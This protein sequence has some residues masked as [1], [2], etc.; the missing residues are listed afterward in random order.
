MPTSP[1]SAEQ[2]TTSV[3]KALGSYADRI[4][5][6]GV[7]IESK[8]A[9]SSSTS[10]STKMT[11]PS[12]PSKTSAA[13]SS[14]TKTPAS[15]PKSNSAA[16]EPATAPQ[17]VEDDGPWETVQSAR[18][19]SK[20]DKDKEREQQD[21]GS[22]SRNWR[23]RPT[24][25]KGGGSSSKENVEN[26][27]EG[28]KAGASTSAANHQAGTSSSSKSKRATSSAPATRS[29]SEAG[30][31]A[32]ATTPVA[33]TS[34]N[35]AGPPSKSAWSTPVT[36]QKTAGNSTSAESSTSQPTKSG[37][38]GQS[39]ARTAP[40]SPSLNGTTVAN[41]S[42]G[43]N[44]VASPHQSTETHVSS[45]PPTSA[46]IKE[47]DNE[48]KGSVPKES[49]KTSDKA[50]EKPSTTT[51]KEAT[52]PAT[53]AIPKAAPAPPTNVWA[54]RQK[55]ITSA[56]ALSTPQ[57]ASTTDHS[58]KSTPARLQFGELSPSLETPKSTPNG[59]AGEPVKIG[60][61]KKK[62][63][64]ASVV[65]GQAV[66]MDA[67]QWPD[68]V[69]AQAVVAE[70]SKSEAKK[71]TKQVEE[72]QDES[73]TTSK[74][75]S[76]DRVGPSALSSSSADNDTEKPKW[77]AIPASELLAAADEAAA[78]AAAAAE[79]NKR[80]QRKRGSKQGESSTSPTAKTVGLP[81]KPRKGG[82][83]DGK[84]GEIRLPPNP[85]GQ[86]GKST[87]KPTFG[88]LEPGS[89]LIDEV[90]S[91]TG[92][93]T[94]AVAN[95]TSSVPLSR[96]TSKT[97]QSPVRTLSDHSIPLEQAIRLGA[98]PLKASGQTHQNATA[99]LPQ[100]PFASASSAHTHP[101]PPRG[102]RNS[103]S[104][105][106]RGGGRGGRF[107]PNFA[108]AGHASNSGNVY[109]QGYGMGYPVNGFYGQHAAYPA[110]A[111]GVVGHQ[112]PMFDPMQA[113]WFNMQMYGRGPMPPPPTPQTVVAGLNMDPLRFYVLGQVSLR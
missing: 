105:R 92:D 76:R 93:V 23:D 56:T 110:G 113:Q 30:K 106:G 59:N 64:A 112:Q 97:S 94:A 81:G 104:G 82:A 109:A 103:F 84:R 54:T 24:K 75:A 46:A 79:A 16:V 50:D 95:G 67:S 19:K 40:S 101:R 43:D 8:P 74:S 45:T 72:Q 55:P 87:F 37:K 22:N 5:E 58:E 102:G 2:N 9:P 3:F 34:R 27:G 33:S 29:G 36:S 53:P 99:P 85:N 66:I 78:A 35:P 65:G 111:P 96:Q 91:T 69:T 48:G 63:D 62:K 39:R 57:S 51:T 68:V 10:T 7:N 83:G 44:S 52:A 70:T 98:G 86:A 25:E 31:P 108:G 18:V 12:A 4:R 17:A 38:G 41:S 15:A 20:H 11:K 100:Q 14:S 32:A 90:V 47:V 21:K 80:Q 49:V 71:E 107:D 42:A 28:R 73:T 61:K 89:E 88:S 13:A 6:N 1:T 77:K 26:A 60:G